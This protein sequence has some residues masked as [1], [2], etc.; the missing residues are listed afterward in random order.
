MVSVPSPLNRRFNAPSCQTNSRPKDRQS[1][2]RE[3]FPQHQQWIE[4]FADSFPR[5]RS[6]EL[7]NNI[8]TVTWV[9]PPPV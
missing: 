9:I 6:N 8:V 3:K 4:R 7:K 1:Q 5:P 2:T